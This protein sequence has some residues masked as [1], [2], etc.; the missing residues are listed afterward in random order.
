MLPMAYDLVAASAGASVLHFKR[1]YTCSPDVK[2]TIRTVT[3]SGALLAEHSFDVPVA[4]CRT[5]TSGWEDDSLL[6]M[7]RTGSTLYVCSADGRL[8]AISLGRAALPAR[9][10][11]TEASTC[12]GLAT[13]CII[14]QQSEVLI[15]D[16]AHQ[17]VTHRHVLHGAAVDSS[18][19]MAATFTLPKASMA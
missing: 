11:C 10:L 8:L 3:R 9:E 12:N 5:L 19:S 7:A 2:G 1:A 15:V 13:V 4:P 16:L 14:G 17:W 6:V 18:A